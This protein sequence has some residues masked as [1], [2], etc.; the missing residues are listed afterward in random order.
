MWR[1]VKSDTIARLSSAQAR[2]RLVARLKPTECPRPRNEHS[3]LTYVL[4]NATAA[5]SVPFSSKG[6]ANEGVFAFA[7]ERRR[8]LKMRGANREL[9]ASLERFTALLLPCTGKT[10]SMRIAKGCRNS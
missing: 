5:G 1:L 7:S 3:D 9:P 6:R 10:D 8:A 4:A 2:L